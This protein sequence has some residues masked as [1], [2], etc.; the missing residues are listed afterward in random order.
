MG[1]PDQMKESASFL[2]DA[3]FS[4]PA[5]HSAVLTRAAGSY[6]PDSIEALVQDALLQQGLSQ[7]GVLQL[8]AL[9]IG[10]EN[11]EP[12]QVQAAQVPSQGFE[13]GDHVGRTI[14]LGGLILHPELRE[15]AQQVC[16]DLCVCSQVGAQP[17]EEGKHQQAHLDLSHIV[18]G[19]RQREGHLAQLLRLAQHDL[20]GQ[21]FAQLISEVLHHHRLQAKAR[22][23][24]SLHERT[25]RERLQRLQY[26]RAQHP[27][28][29]DLYEGVELCPLAQPSEPGEQQVLQGREPPHLLAQQRSDAVEDQFPLLQKAVEVSPEEVG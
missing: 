12:R 24:P 21:A 9:Q 5:A 1:L 18:L 15:Q 7:I 29:Q 19:L 13:Q 27:G 11:G 17:L 14:A 25:P 20:L 10:S 4:S 26:L 8:D 3:H 2:P 23:L 16:L 28:M 6:R 22:L